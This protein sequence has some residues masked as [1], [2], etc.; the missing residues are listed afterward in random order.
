MKT[1]HTQ[2]R[3]DTSVNC[4]DLNES[5]ETSFEKRKRKKRRKRQKNAERETQTEEE[6]EEK[7][8]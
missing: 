6:A 8:R 1:D 4:R 2:E 5:N 3:N 7:E